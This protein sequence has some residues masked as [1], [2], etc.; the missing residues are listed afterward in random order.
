MTQ[1]WGCTSGYAGVLDGT[2]SPVGTMRRLAHAG[3][4][5]RGRGDATRGVGSN[6]EWEVLSTQLGGHTTGVM[7]GVVYA[8]R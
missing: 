1:C 4:R 6:R 2:C 8:V 7:H 3:S 5:A